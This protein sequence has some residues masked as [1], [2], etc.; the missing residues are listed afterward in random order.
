VPQALTELKA[1]LDQPS[2]KAPSIMLRRMKEDVLDSLPEKR[3]EKYLTPMPDVQAGA[4]SAVVDE[5]RRGKADRMTILK[6]VHAL[7]GVSLHPTGTEDIDPYSE[8]S[9]RC[10]IA[11][12]AR[13]SKTVELLHSIKAKSE[14]AIIFIED[15]GVQKIFADAALLLF[16]LAKSPDIIN[17]ETPGKKA[18]HCRQVSSRKKWLRSPPAVSTRG[19]RRADDHRPQVRNQAL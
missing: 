6:A 11:A 19:G 18:G 12:S 10:W 13:L 14:K 15:L 8:Q 16:G 1:R 17:G 5:A 3:V 9:C 2:G 7:R 4:Y